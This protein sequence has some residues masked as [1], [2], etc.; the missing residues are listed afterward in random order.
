MTTVIR[1]VHLQLIR[2]CRFQAS[3]LAGFYFVL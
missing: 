2:V 3:V 1:V